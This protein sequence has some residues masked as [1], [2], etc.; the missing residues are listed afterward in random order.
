VEN[1]AARERGVNLERYVTIGESQEEL[2]TNAPRTRG[3]HRTLRKSNRRGTGH[4]SSGA[5]ENRQTLGR[6][7]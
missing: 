4:G 5:G 7:F 2:E 3:K 1:G 6:F